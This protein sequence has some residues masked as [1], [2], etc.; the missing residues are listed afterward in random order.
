MAPTEKGR[1]GQDSTDQRRPA[2]R[3]GPGAAAA[4]AP[5]RPRGS[6]ER[7]L[8]FQR[9]PVGAALFPFRVLSLSGGPSSGG[10]QGALAIT[11]IPIRIAGNGGLAAV[12]ALAAA[13]PPSVA[14]NAVADCLRPAVRPPAAGFVLAQSRVAVLAAAI[15]TPGTPSAVGMSR[16]GVG[17]PIR[18]LFAVLSPLARS[19]ALPLGFDG[20]PRGVGLRQ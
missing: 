2:P 19:R 6:L 8:L 5:C 9:S 4:P 11:G 12:L 3:G 18:W 20:Q 16:S 1:S 14:S 15:P 10:A 17:R 13:V 7:L